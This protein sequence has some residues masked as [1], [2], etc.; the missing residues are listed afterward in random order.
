MNY[1]YRDFDREIWNDELE[2]FV[3]S[4]IYDLHCHFW[5]EAHQG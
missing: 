4:V 2:A 3:P 5:S 1:D